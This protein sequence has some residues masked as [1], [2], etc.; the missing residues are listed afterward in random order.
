MSSSSH[1]LLLRDSI[2]LRVVLTKF[3]CVPLL[4]LC[5]FPQLR[6]LFYSHPSAWRADG[7]VL[8]SKRPGS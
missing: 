6:L 3:S 2:L 7:T 1:A 4:G 5:F 8:T